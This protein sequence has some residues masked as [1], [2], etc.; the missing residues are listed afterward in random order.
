MARTRSKGPASPVANKVKEQSKV[1]KP[2]KTTKPSPKKDSKPKADPQEEDIVDL[3]QNDASF[4]ISNKVTD[5]AISELKSYIAR[6]QSK[7]E[8]KA[9]QNPSSKSQ[10]FDD[11]DSDDSTLTL[12]VESKKF[13]SSKP[14]FKPK[15]I[16]LFKSIN[17]A[18]IKS[19]LIIRDQLVKSDQ[20]IEKIEEANLPTVSQILPLQSIKTE[21]K[22]YEKRRELHSSFDLFFVDDAVLNTMPTSLGK[23]FYQTSKYPLPVRVS[24]SGNKKELSLTTLSNQLQKALSSTSY[25]PPQGTTVSIKIGSI[26]DEFTLEDLNKNINAVA[27]S[28]NISTIKSI[29]LKTATSPALPLYYTDKLYDE[30][31]IFVE[32]KEE[33][34]NGDELSAFE[35]GLLELGDAET[36]AK[37]IGKKLGEKK[38]AA[39]KGKVKK[40]RK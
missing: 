20:E 22:P 6:E 8:K 25:L 5:K 3:K 28:F 26:N 27:S 35:K 18:S 1:T 17:D 14:Q 31:D 13:L 29:M 24:T 34:T 4:I 30:D 36:V 9:S 23:I 37:V 19:C 16:K 15:S 21:Y 11:E 40:L 2:K 33:T 12:V 32:T 39:A 7:R 38:R 10:L